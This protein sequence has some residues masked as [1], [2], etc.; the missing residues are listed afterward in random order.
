MENLSEILNLAC[1]VGRGAA[2]I[3]QS[4]YHGTAKDPNLDIQ[5]KENEPVTLADLAVN[6]YILTSLQAALG[7]EK[8]GYISE[9]TYKSQ[10]SKDPAELVWI[11]DPLDGTR[12]FIKKTGD[13]AVH[14]A[15]VQNH[16][17]VLAVVAVPEAQKLY[18]AT[19]GGGAFVETPNG[20]MPLQ[21]SQG[22]PI[23]DLTVVVSSSHRHGK[24]E[25]LLQNLPCQH[26]KS[27]GSVGCKIATIVEQQADIYISLSGQSAPKD[28][29]MAAPELILTESG[30]KF[31]H[32]DGSPLQYN[33]DD[34]NQWGGLLASNG[35]YQEILCQ[36]AEKILNQFPGN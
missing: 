28:W 7:Q 6:Q 1:D 9:E 12:D 3:L 34:I 4:Y 17:P 16:R 36:S 24:L 14:I 25:Y 19:I 11:I 22:K 18:Y 32:F 30:G 23:E 8:F 29:D 35:Q 33:T 5:Y 21:V 26:Q 31:T 20:T 2:N 27:I 15:L 13:Y 10:Q